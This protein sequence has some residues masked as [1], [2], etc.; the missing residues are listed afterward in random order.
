MKALYRLEFNCGRQGD[1]Y[2][3]FV[4]DKESVDILV[5]EC[6]SV[7]FGEALGKHSEVYGEVDASEVSMITDDKNVIE[8][9]DEYD[10]STGFNPFDHYST[11]FDFDKYG[12]EEDDITVSE[13][14][15]LIKS[16]RL[17]DAK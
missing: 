2:G 8:T 13:I 7:N 6:I 12:I 1:L 10:L 15:E 9:V 14:V 5:T 11:D 17:N 16:K 3:I 4:A